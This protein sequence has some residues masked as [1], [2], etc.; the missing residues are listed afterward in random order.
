MYLFVPSDIKK[1]CK[2]EL[3]LRLG[4]KFY[5]DWEAEDG[6]LHYV[7]VSKNT[8]KVPNFTHF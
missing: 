1:Y 2:E 3:G 5:T 4:D 8:I 6:M 7:Y